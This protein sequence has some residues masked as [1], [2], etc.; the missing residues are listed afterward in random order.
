LLKKPQLLSAILLNTTMQKL[1]EVRHRWVRV[2][3]M[4]GLAAVLF[5]PLGPTAVKA[6][7]KT[8]STSTSTSS[9]SGQPKFTVCHKG[10]T[11]ITISKAAYDTHLAHG[12]TPGPCVVTTVN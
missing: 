6:D 9:G 8:T 2:I 1:N 4:A 7:T 10:V 5:V 12:D 11:T 3:G